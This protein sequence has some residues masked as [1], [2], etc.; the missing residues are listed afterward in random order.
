M[1]NVNELTDQTTISPS[2][3]PKLMMLACVL[4]LIILVELY[5]KIIGF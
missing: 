3:K 4:G 1:T 5:A 2:S